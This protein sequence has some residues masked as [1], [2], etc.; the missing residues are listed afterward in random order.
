MRPQ[1]PG[2]V[3]KPATQLQKGESRDRIP[4]S[5]LDAGELAQLPTSSCVKIWAVGA[6]PSYLLPWQVSEQLE[7]TGSGFA[8]IVDGQWRLLTNAHV[9]DNAIVVRVTRQS[10]SR[11]IKAEVLVLAHDLDLALLDVPDESFRKTVP[12]VELAE[13]LPPLFSEVKA[14]GYPEGGNTICVTKGVVSRVDAQLYAHA[15][16]KGIL[17]GACSNPGKLLI[18]QIDAAINCGNS[19]GPAVDQEGK[20]VGVASSGL[21]TAQNVGYI[22]PACLVKNFLHEF[23]ISRSWGGIPELGLTYRALES[24]PLRDFLQVPPG[25]SGVQITSV[26]P[27]GVLGQCANRGDVLLAIDGQTVSNEGTVLLGLSSGHEV[28]L[29]FEH[30]I[31]SKRRGERTDLLVLR[32]KGGSAYE[33]KVSVEFKPIPPL[34]P[35]FD[36]YDALPSYF[37]FGGLVFTRLSIPFYQEYCVS[38]EMQTL[39]VPEAAL[40]KVRV[41]RESQE[42]VLILMRVLTH[43]VNEGID[44]L[45]VRLL[46]S[47]NGEPVCTMDGLVRAA[48]SA[49]A[50]KQRFV[51]F[52]FFRH[53]RYPGDGDTVEVLRADEVLAAD[54]EILAQHQISAPVSP[55]LESIYRAHAPSHLAFVAAWLSCLRSLAG[56]RQRKHSGNAAAISAVEVSDIVP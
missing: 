32:R 22:I 4:A 13:G 50:S 23:V 1:I 18:V 53:G 47:V 54:Q 37:I 36:G 27:L 33:E 49:V 3:T 16:M 10:E 14:I 24:A 52:G 42:E 21:D 41:W 15:E 20:V 12:V 44:R 35:R 56:C 30:L 2:S 48:M 43:D 17:P 38:E 5:P 46:E 9:V 19:G 34:L 45:S 6:A 8:V 29:P 26:A 11:K 7:W 51:R 39:V 28:Q 25:K 55:D 40:E 31:T